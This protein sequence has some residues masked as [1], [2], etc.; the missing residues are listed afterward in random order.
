MQFFKNAKE[1]AQYLQSQKWRAKGQKNPVTERTV[2]LH[3]KAGLLTSAKGKGFSLEAVES[4][5]RGFLEDD[6][7]LVE[8]SSIDD[9]IKKE[10]LRKLRIENDK[11]SGELVLLSEEIKRRVAVIQDIKSGLINH[12]A[13]FARRLS[14]Q[15]K[16][17]GHDGE[18]LSDLLIDAADLYEDGVLEVFD[19]MGKERGA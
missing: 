19:A 7:S 5:A 17:R 3:V 4:Y 9:A 13:T 18:L 16:K 6:A 12:R 8:K 1:V 14:E 11:K 10:Q 15:L 2:Q